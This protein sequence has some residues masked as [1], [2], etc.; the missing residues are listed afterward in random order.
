MKQERFGFAE[1]SRRFADL[2]REVESF[3]VRVPEDSALIGLASDLV[4]KVVHLLR[5]GID[6]LEQVEAF[7]D[8][9]RTQPDKPADSDTLHHIGLM[10]SSEFA[11]RDL[12]DV[13]FFARSEL[14]SSYEYL[15]KSATRRMPGRP[16]E[17]LLT[18]ASNTETGLRA[19]RKAMVSVESAVYE[20]EEQ[21]A[22]KRQWYDVELSLQIRKL[23]WNLR[24]ETELAKGSAEQDLEGRLRQVLYRIMAFREL[25]VYPF[26]RVDDRVNLRHLLKRILDWLNGDERDAT[27][28]RHIWQDLTG[29]AEILVQV[30]HRQELQDHDRDLV[31]RVYYQLFRR[32]DLDMV[33]DQT[34][35]ELEVVLGLDAKLDQLIA[36]KVKDL[37]SW[38]APLRRV[39]DHL[40]RAPSVA[41]PENFWI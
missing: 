13:A 2:I 11:A 5:R 17:D 10:I 32:A 16:I 14:R 29:F 38:R 24:R 1:F 39:L 3:D 27:E 25:S 28:A 19:L 7:Y 34:I 33:P 41:T 37:E 22:P 36:G 35:K 30:S 9:E 8:P 18:M 4:P 23:Y 40:K 21:E 15:M 26:L 6:L 12:I 20:F 31:S